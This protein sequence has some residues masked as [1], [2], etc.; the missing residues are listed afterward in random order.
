MACLTF[1]VVA[2][3]WFFVLLGQ[4]KFSQD[5]RSYTLDPIVGAW[6]SQIPGTNPGSYGSA[7]FTADGTAL[8]TSSW[9]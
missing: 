3:I 5:R 9:I 8:L 7:I 4:G 1:S 6:G 2:A